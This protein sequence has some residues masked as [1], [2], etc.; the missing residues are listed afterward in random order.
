MPERSRFIQL[1]ILL[2]PK[3]FSAQSLMY[4]QERGLRSKINIDTGDGSLRTSR[5]SSRPLVP[6]VSI[7]LVI[8]NG[9][10]VLRLHSVFHDLQKDQNLWMR[11]SN[12][13]LSFRKH[14]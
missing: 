3:T 5:M 13:K 4:Q 7:C 8:V 1:D 11:N 10:L 12:L 14:H 2:L 6:N 9:F